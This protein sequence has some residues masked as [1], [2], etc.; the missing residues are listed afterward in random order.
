VAGPLIGIRQLD[1]ASNRELTLSAARAERDELVRVQVAEET[2]LR[3]FLEAGDRDAMAADGPPNRSFDVHAQRLRELMTAAAL[4]AMLAEVDE[5]ADAHD[6]WERSMAIP[7]AA[8]PRRHDAPLLMTN[9]K[10]L[11]DGFREVASRLREQL[12]EADDRGQ[13]DLA[14]RIDATVVIST[15]VVVLFALAAVLLG[16]DRGSALMRL[17][18]ERMLVD[19]L[20]RALRVGGTRLPRTRIGFAYAS[21]TR[22]ALIGG[23]LLDVWRAPGGG[24]LLVADASGKGIEAARHS[25]FVQYAMRALAAEHGEPGMVVSRFNQLFI[26]TFTDPGTF[27]VLFLAHVDVRRGLISYV[28]AGHSTA[29]VRR[30]EEVE[31]L[32]VTGPVVGIDAAAAFETGEVRL[33]LGDALLLATDGVTEA[34]DPAGTFLGDDGVAELFRNG[35]FEPQAVC[36]VLLGEVERRSGGVIRD[37][38][39]ILVFELFDRQNDGS[40]DI[41]F[42]TME[43]EAES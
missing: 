38:L 18:R 14:N 9:G 15:G 31:Q 2:A 30:G 17:E 42:T 4:T 35:P 43:A 37:D 32:K 29:F 8:D 41:S 23:D 24:W 5:L 13:A 27:V 22:E 40:E 34:R 7:L 12:R 20:Q 11:T 39:A 33:G 10:L 25:A 36:D 28:S 19:S 3:A 6:R 21:A 26:E 1:T 16:L